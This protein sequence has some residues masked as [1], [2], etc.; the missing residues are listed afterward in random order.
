MKIY[1]DALFCAILLLIITAS[2]AFPVAFEKRKPRDEKVILVPRGARP[3]LKE[4]YPRR[5][6]VV[7]RIKARRK[8]ALIIPFIRSWNTAA[9]TALRGI[10]MEETPEIE[11]DDFELGFAL[12][13]QRM[14]MG[15]LRNREY[16]R[17][18]TA[19]FPEGWYRPLDTMDRANRSKG[20]MATSFA[21]LAAKRIRRKHI[22]YRDFT[23][24]VSGILNAIMA[25]NK[26]L[27]LTACRDM[28][29]FRAEGGSSQPR[30]KN[31]AGIAYI[32][33]GK[34]VN[35]L[36]VDGGSTW[37]TLTD[38]MQRDFQYI[39]G[40]SS[41][42]WGRTL[43]RDFDVNL[44]GKA[45]I[46]ALREQ[47][48]SADTWDIKESGWLGILNTLS[49]AEFLKLK[50][51]ASALYD[52]E[53]EFYFTPGAE[54]AVPWNVIEANVGV[55]KQAILPDFDEIYW[56]SKF[57][58]VNDDLQPEDFWEAYAAFEVDIPARLAFLVKASYSRPESR[59]TWEQ[60]PEYVWEPVNVET[61][62]ALTG[63]ASLT[64]NLI[65]SFDTFASCRYQ[66]FDD[67]R[68]D[69]E[70]VATGGFSY[71]NPSRGSV[72]LGASF[73]NFQPMENMGSPENFTFVYGRINKSIHGVLSIFVDG[74]YTFNDEAILY[75]R[76]M[77]QAGRI[78]SVGANI[79]F[80]G[81]E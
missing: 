46:S 66:R 19:G 36:E 29:S 31:I 7:D 40:V 45:R 78:V 4:E 65:G 52:S 71:G 81:L 5:Q 75:Y 21:H 76:G 61:F 22:G 16:F 12:H 3:I 30:I 80:G 62:D 37:S 10:G 15:A 54:L 2:Q 6:L 24:R 33:P 59:I 39:S 23:D 32:K 44:K 55:R 18:Q 56:Q 41:V 38:S 51:N 42:T 43:H 67:Q 60:L 50:L 28:Q 8:P 69:P 35:K 11:P 17:S 13:S 26:Q 48:D 58:K 72:T 25:Q 68:F 27:T 9:L 47:T 49:L 34:G 77:P 73:W 1:R 64:A 53:Y 70:I 20:Y 63:E 79:V 14:R 74:R 57:V